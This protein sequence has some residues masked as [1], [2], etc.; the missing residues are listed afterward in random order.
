MRLK[1]DIDLSEFDAVHRRMSARAKN[2]TPVFRKLAP[3]LEA[4]QKKHG[5]RR[6]AP[7]GKW[8]P[9][10]PATLARRQQDLRSK[11]KRRQKRAQKLGAALPLG[12]L[13]RSVAIE[14][15]RRVLWARAHSWADDFSGVQQEG[16]T[17]GRGSRIPA[18]TFLWLSNDFIE[19]AVNETLVHLGKAIR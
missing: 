7:N 8:P 12:V 15:N 18:R 2:M 16:G 19:A 10:A 14:W 11:V 3:Q 6:E 5:R 9:L 13:R 17:V 1:V 4:D